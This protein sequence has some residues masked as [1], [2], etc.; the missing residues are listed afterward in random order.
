MS[1]VTVI[2]LEV[3]VPVKPPGLE[4]AMYPVISDPPLLVGG[5]NVIEACAFPAVAV[6]IIG[7]SG[8]VIG[9]EGMTEFETELAL[10]VPLAFVAVTVKV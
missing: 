4:V 9:A 3:P 7:A 6:P 10:L 1:P 2:G 8:T 5:V